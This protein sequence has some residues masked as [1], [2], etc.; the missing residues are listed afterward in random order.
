LIIND[1]ASDRSSL[2]A[3]QIDLLLNNF[4]YQNVTGKVFTSN[5][6]E[7]KTQLNS[8]S[9]RQEENKDPSWQAAVTAAKGKD[10]V[11]D[12]LGKKNG[13][14]NIKSWELKDVTLN[15]VSVKNIRQLSAANKKTSIG[16]INGSYF[17]ADNRFDWFNV[18]FDKST[19]LLTLDSF[20]YNPAS[21]DMFTKQHPFQADYFHISAG[22]TVIGAFDIDSYLADSIIRIDKMTVNDIVFDDYRDMRLPFRSG[23]IK[24]LIGNRIKSIP[25]KLSVDSLVVNNARITYAETSKQTKETG[26]IPV[27]R[28]NIKVFPIRNFDLSKTDSLS[29]QA[30]GYLFDSILVNIRMRESY[31]DSLSG[32]LLV[33]NIDAADL[34]ILNPILT[35]L[36]YAKIR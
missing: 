36:S 22:N 19:K 29:L 26:T 16:N 34:R 23:I 9:Y 35:T 13:Q 21:K 11:F 25:L 28:L 20:L 33:A 32:F 30:T 10:F 6:A 7:I 12:S 2:S 31:A 18:G 27:S 5:K 4:I 14:L 15:N 24:P 3:S 17:T 8:F 1:I